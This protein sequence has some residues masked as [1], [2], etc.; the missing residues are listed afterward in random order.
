MEKIKQTV[1][2][3]EHTLESA[4][5]YHAYIVSH[6]NVENKNS[7]QSDNNKKDNGR[8]SKQRFLQ[9]LCLLL[10]IN[11]SP[12]RKLKGSICL[13]MIWLLDALSSRLT[14]GISAL[15]CSREC[16]VGQLSFFSR[17]L[18]GFHVISLCGTDVWI[19]QF[20]FCT[21]VLIK[22]LPNFVRQ[23]T[24]FCDQIRSAC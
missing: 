16:S 22:L 18:F 11:H 2:I 14:G 1:P 10:L 5:V 3:A 9:R 12:W 13:K 24:N 4:Y 21:I 15:T 7:A 6:V 19:T 17:L 8:C 23:T 20:P